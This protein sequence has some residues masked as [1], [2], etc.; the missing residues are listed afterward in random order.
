ML[1]IIDAHGVPMD[2]STYTGIKNAADPHSATEMCEYIHCLAWMRNAIPRFTERTAPFPKF[3]EVG[4]F[5]A[6]CKDT[7]STQKLP[8]LWCDPRRVVS[9]K[10]YAICVYDDLLTRKY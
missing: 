10:I 4:D 9:V 8:F 6:I 3:F 2:P 5:V 7:R 1:R